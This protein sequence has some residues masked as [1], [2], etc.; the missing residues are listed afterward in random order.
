MGF[1]SRLTVAVQQAIVWGVQAAV[2]LAIVAFAVLWLAGDYQIVR[3]RAY[4]GQVAFEWIQQQQ[5]AK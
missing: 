4:N 1:W 2:V 5:K 3:A